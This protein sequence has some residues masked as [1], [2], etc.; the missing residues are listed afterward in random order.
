MI[1]FAAVSSRTFDCPAN[2]A[3]YPA[4]SF[5][6]LISSRTTGTAASS[7]CPG[8]MSADTP[9]AYCR[10]SRVIEVGPS[11]RCSLATLSI[12]TRLPVVEPTIRPP[13]AWTSLR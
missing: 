11:P 10:S 2:F 6:F 13:T 4:G 5:S 1:M 8:R 7:A 3:R 9:M 12:R